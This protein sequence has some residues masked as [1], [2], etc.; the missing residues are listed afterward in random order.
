[1]KESAVLGELTDDSHSFSIERCGELLLMPI[2]IA[3]RACR[4]TIRT[5]KSETHAASKVNQSMLH[6]WMMIWISY[7]YFQISIS[8]VHS[9]CFLDFPWFPSLFRSIQFNQYNWSLYVLTKF[10]RFNK[11]WFGRQRRKKKNRKQNKLWIVKCR[12][13]IVA[14]YLIG[15]QKAFLISR[16]TE[17]SSSANGK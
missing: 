11:H 3:S 6:I 16:R 2:N 10:E 5:V 1:M 17:C 9:V 12:C 13:R 4:A 7:I 15:Q 14:N 8:L